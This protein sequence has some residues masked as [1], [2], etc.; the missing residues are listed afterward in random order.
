MDTRQ[1]AICD[2]MISIYIDILTLGTQFP[3]KIHNP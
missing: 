1:H 3:K 2:E